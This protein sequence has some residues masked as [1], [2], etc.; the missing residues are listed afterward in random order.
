MA[1]KKA[2]GVPKQTP[3]APAEEAGPRGRVRRT[4]P[5]KIAPRAEST[6]SGPGPRYGGGAPVRRGL[7]VTE[8]WGGGVQRGRSSREADRPAAAGQAPRGDVGGR[9]GRSRTTGTGGGIQSP[10][11]DASWRISGRRKR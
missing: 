5:R 9:S 7:G 1:L 11:D 8:D 10:G 3:H 2:F 4:T 6:G